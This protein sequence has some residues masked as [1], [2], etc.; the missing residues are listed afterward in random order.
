MT[1][2]KKDI[3]IV[4]YMAQDKVPLFQSK[5]VLFNFSMKIHVVVFIR[6]ASL[7][8]FKVPQHMVSL[9]ELEFYSPVNI[10]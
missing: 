5:N 3:I 2:Q 6:N 9:S 10:V 7:G 4:S 8:H 1:I